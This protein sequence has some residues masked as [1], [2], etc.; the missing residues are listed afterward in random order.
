MYGIPVVFGPRRVEWTDFEK[1]WFEDIRGT[2]A[3][4]PAG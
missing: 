4:P 1:Q 3:E 2:H